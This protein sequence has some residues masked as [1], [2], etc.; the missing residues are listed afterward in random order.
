MENP[1]EGENKQN[2]ESWSSSAHTEKVITPLNDFHSNMPNNSPPENLPAS[3]PTPAAPPNPASIYPTPVAPGGNFGQPPQQVN[4]ISANPAEQHQINPLTLILQWL[5]YAFWGW[6]VVVLSILTSSVFSRLISGDNIATFNYYIISAAVVLLPISFVCDYFYS[7]QEPEKK[8]GAAMVV[9]II[10][11]VIFALFGIGALIFAVFSFV[12]LFTSPG[13]HG[14]IISALLSSLIITCFYSA[15]FLRTLN[16]QFVTWIPKAYRIMMLVIIG[17]FII[18]GFTKPTFHQVTNNPVSSRKP[19][20]TNPYSTPITTNSSENKFDSNGRLLPSVV[21]GTQCD[22]STLNDNS[23]FAQV[24][25]TGN[26]DCT[27]AETVIADSSGKNGGNY[28]SNGYSCDAT[29]QGAGTQWSSYWN[30]NFYSYN[31]TKGTDQIAFNWQSQ[32]QSN[33]TSATGVGQFYR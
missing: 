18:L 12:T 6:T 15:T 11:A 30:D 32:A 25:V 16:P 8:S 7:K 21:G 1:Q 9:M 26:A 20:Y 27:I 22:I 17:I 5:T 29:K 13:T 19:S 10:H 31:C 4:A 14:P 23:S 33:S 28:K 24:E 2:Q 3:Q